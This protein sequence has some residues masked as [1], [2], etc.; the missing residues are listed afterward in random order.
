MAKIDL[1]QLDD[2]KPDFNQIVANGQI[3]VWDAVNE[4]FIPLDQAAE[5]IVF[6]RAMLLMGG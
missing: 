6:R 5:V 3:P 1:A 4:Y 2:F